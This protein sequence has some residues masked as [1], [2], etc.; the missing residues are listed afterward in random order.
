MSRLPVLAAAAIPAA[1][2]GPARHAGLTPAER[3]LYFWILRRFAAS[4][5]PR[6]ADAREAA[7]RLGLDGERALETLAGED[8]VHLGG[9]GEIVVAYPFSGRPTAHRV[10]FPGGHEAYAMCAIDAVGIAA[11]FGEAIDVSSEDPITGDQVSVRL[12][13]RGDAEWG[14]PAAVVVAG[15]IPGE[16]DSCQACCPVLNFFASPETA[17]HWLEQHPEARGRVTSIPEAAAAGR[18]VFGGVLSER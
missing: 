1:K 2:V 16:G 17:E 7:G 15:A 11:M 5:R 6:S 4:G 8:L 12:T 3:E 9:D 14:P 13:P 10:R 18:A